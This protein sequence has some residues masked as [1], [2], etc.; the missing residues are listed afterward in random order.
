MK[1]KSSVLGRNQEGKEKLKFDDIAIRDFVSDL[2]YLDKEGKV[3][4]KK[5]SFTPINVPKKSRL[6]GLKLF[7]D[8]YRY[9]NQLFSIPYKSYLLLNY[10]QSH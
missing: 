1:V 2:S 5:R 6:K 10:N 8:K 3:K 4:Q 9:I 7:L